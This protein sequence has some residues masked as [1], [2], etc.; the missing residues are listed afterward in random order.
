MLYFYNI[1]FTTGTTCTT[2]HST[3]GTRT[4]LH[5]VRVVYAPLCIIWL[6][7]SYTSTHSQLEPAWNLRHSSSH[8]IDCTGRKVDENSQQLDPNFYISLHLPDL[9][10]ESNGAFTWWGS[11]RAS[12][13]ALLFP[14]SQNNQPCLV[15]VTWY[16]HRPVGRADESQRGKSRQLS[17]LQHGNNT[18]QE[19]ESI[20]CATGKVVGCFIYF[21]RHVATNDANVVNV[22]WTP[23]SPEDTLKSASQPV[24]LRVTRAIQG[25]VPARWSSHSPDPV[26]QDVIHSCVLPPSSFKNTLIWSAG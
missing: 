14:I 6:D 12:H 1:N 9:S 11:H 20:K 17:V 24:L 16:K 19:A 25:Q 13:A 2:L 18:R 7:S 3:R 26:P 5:V 22:T 10:D 15:C 23:V 8:W 4:T 21:V